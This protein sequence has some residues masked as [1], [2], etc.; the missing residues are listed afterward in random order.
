MSDQAETAAAPSTQEVLDEVLRTTLSAVEL[1]GKVVR[2][3]ARTA[4]GTD[5]ATAMAVIE[6]APA[7]IERLQ[8]LLPRKSQRLG[9]TQPGASGRPTPPR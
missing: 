6:R 8:G 9:S 7:L 1:A 4:T 3:E 2:G 5:L